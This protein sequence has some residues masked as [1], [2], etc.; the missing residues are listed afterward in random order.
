MPKYMIERTIQGAANLSNEELQSISQQSRNILAQLG[1]EIQWV[2]SY[3]AGDKFYCVYNAPSEA[4][5]RKHAQ[6]GGF[7]GDLITKIQTIVDP[8]T[9]EA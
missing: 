9:A 7:P 4:L 1:T 5:I 6:K 2:Q 3:V 8:T